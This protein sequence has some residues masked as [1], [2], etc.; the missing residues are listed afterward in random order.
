MAGSMAGGAWR[1]GHGGGGMAAGSNG[2]GK[3]GGNDVPEI[4]ELVRV[5]RKRMDRTVRV[6]AREGGEGV[7]R[8][9]S[10]DGGSSECGKVRCAQRERGGDGRGQRGCGV[11]VGEREG[12]GGEDEG[13]VVGIEAGRRMEEDA[14]RERVRVGGGEVVWRSDEGVEGRG[15]GR[16]HA[17]DVTC[18]RH[19]EHGASGRWGPARTERE[20]GGWG[21]HTCRGDARGRALKDC[22]AQRRAEARARTALKECEH[23]SGKAEGRA[24]G[25]TDCRLGERH[26]Q[27]GAIGSGFDWGRRSGSALCAVIDGRRRPTA[28][29][30]ATAGAR[31]ALGRGRRCRWEND[32]IRVSAHRR[33]AIQCG[34]GGHGG[35]CVRCVPGVRLPNGAGW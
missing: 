18:D 1:G 35:G 8:G 29:S 4:G 22:R 6:C 13:A 3:H 9:G 31:G 28:E 15:G 7:R 19:V 11:A 21:A 25:R 23:E 2:G 33:R 32:D 27:R 24:T 10:V 16:R 14:H 5:K 26:A 12:Q 34:G 20:R 17:R 30:H